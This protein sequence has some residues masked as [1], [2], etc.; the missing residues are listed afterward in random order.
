VEITLDPGPGESDETVLCVKALVSEIKVFCLTLAD[1]ARNHYHPAV[2]VRPGV[3]MRV[4]ILPGWW[5]RPA[6]YF[7]VG[8]ELQRCGYTLEGWD[9]A[10]GLLYV[11]SCDERQQRWRYAPAS[12]THIASDPVEH[13]SKVSVAPPTDRVEAVIPGDPGLDLTIRTPVFRSPDGRWDAFVACHVYGPEDV[14]LVAT[15]D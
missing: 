2:A 9:Q 13:L 12:D 4:P 10:G 11:E 3:E 8:A 6:K 5:A 7:R 15:S 14:V 1:V